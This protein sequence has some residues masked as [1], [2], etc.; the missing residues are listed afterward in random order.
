MK[1]LS[2][3]LAELSVR[4]K[5][6]EDRITATEAQSATYP[7]TQLQ[8]LPKDTPA[9]QTFRRRLHALPPSP[10]PRKP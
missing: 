2:Q 9:F 6:A 7:A 3:Q 1:S 10:T 5:T 8:R 4:A